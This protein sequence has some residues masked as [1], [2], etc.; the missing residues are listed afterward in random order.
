MHYSIQPGVSVNR[1]DEAKPRFVRRCNLRGSIGRAM[2][3]KYQDAMALGGTFVLF[4]KVLQFEQISYNFLIRV[5]CCIQPKSNKM[6]IL[7][8]FAT[9][10]R[11][12]EAARAGKSTYACGDGCLSGRVSKPAR[13]GGT[14]SMHKRVSKSMSMSLC[15]C[16]CTPCGVP[17]TQVNPKRSA[18]PRSKLSDACPRCPST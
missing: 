10:A 17:S 18:S 14:Y 1:V 4:F 7:K 8:I 15:A 12:Y 11:S 9:Q 3:T 6:S 16:M 5:I 13:A 2:G